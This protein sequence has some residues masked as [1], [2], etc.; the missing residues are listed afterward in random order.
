MQRRAVMTVVVGLMAMC[1][2]GPAMAQAERPS[3]QDRDLIALASPELQTFASEQDFR[4]Y[5][6]EVSRLYQR[7]HPR[8]GRYRFS[9]QD[10]SQGPIEIVVAQSAI[11]IDCNA[12]PDSD[13]CV[14][15]G[16]GS[17]VVTGSRVST[18]TIT[19][20]QVAG[21]DE[22]DIVKQI[23]EYL[24][25]LQDGRIF[26]IHY[27]S[28]R[29][30][31][32]IDV[33]RRYERGEPIG[34]DWYDEMLVQGDQAII[35]AYSYEDSASEI[36]VFRLDQ[37]SGRFTRRGVFLISSEDYYDVDNYATRIIGDRLI[38][39]TPFAAR[40]LLDARKRPVVRRW[41]PGE[42]WEE[43]IG[44]GRQLIDARRIYRPVF[45]LEEPYVHSIS[46]CPL[47]DVE[48]RGLECETTGFVGTE[49]ADMFVTPENVYL[50]MPAV[51]PSDWRSYDCPAVTGRASPSQIVP[52]AIVRLPVGRGELAV[53]SA[54]GVNFDQFSMDEHDGRFRALVS[55]RRH[56]CGSSYD[57]PHE[58]A[59]ID[60]PR[61]AF[62]PTYR[63]ARDSRFIALPDPGVPV[64]EN[65]F[66]GDWLVY[67][68]RANYSGRPD[69]L[70]EGEK[71]LGPSAYAVP[72]GRPQAATAIGQP[73]NVIRIERIGDD[74]LL[75]GYRDLGGLS[76]TYLD[77]DGPALIS[78]LRLDNRFESEGRS[79][80]FNSKVS[81]TGGGV[82]GVPTVERHEDAGRWWWNS[83]V[84]DLS[85]LTF[86]SG[87]RLADAG[88]L[89]GKPEQEVVTAAGYECEVSCIDWYGNTRPFFLGGK[90]YGL[91]A[92][93]LI[94]AELVEG[95][96]TERRR[97]DLTGAL[98]A[99]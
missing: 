60:E 17:I 11:Q 5:L 74:I 38:I 4:R 76:L 86:D 29:V 56:Y 15:E 78:S 58:V 42:D 50:W 28:M 62:G 87:G 30:T 82:L 48:A 10:S 57:Q 25:V 51:D 6:R 84:S 36:S 24:L 49:L 66:A 26:A 52:A 69:D 19:N 73:H 80:A 81:E 59:L 44:Q 9:Q 33:Y 97:V 40:D 70:E 54:R 91:M 68:G 2:A 7:R 90:V 47:S 37:Q 39:K 22:G 18:P 75:T 46:I 89:R 21:V 63:E 23:G 98:S 83:T 72:L 13:A 79:H 61:S 8:S 53:M 99:R 96:V 95:K 64:V 93:D 88:L 92:T 94:E 45:G 32:R 16:R 43:T 27:P 20:V 85:Y 14:P 31:D 3:F 65:R 12:T 77:L 35:T 41:Q 71:N 34:A 55:W 67:G 1:F